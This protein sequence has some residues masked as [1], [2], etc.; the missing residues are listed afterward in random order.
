M[1]GTTAACRCIQD[2]LGRIDTD[3]VR[4]LAAEHLGVTDSG[5]EGSSALP[6]LGAPVQVKMRR[7]VSW[8]CM[9]GLLRYHYSFLM[10]YFYMSVCLQDIALLHPE[11]AHAGGPNYSSAIRSMVYFR[12]KSM[13]LYERGRDKA[14]SAAFHST[15]EEDNGAKPIAGDISQGEDEYLSDMWCDFRGLAAELGK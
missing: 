6:Y 5:H 13:G 9:R 8:L 1:H 10:C 4:A 2:H 15:A 11:T 3:K 14:P 7:G 12:V